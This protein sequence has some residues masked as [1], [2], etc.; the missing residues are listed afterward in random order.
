MD[1]PTQVK[2]I[3][4]TEEGAL[5]NKDNLALRQYKEQKKRINTINT[6]EDRICVLERQIEQILETGIIN[7]NS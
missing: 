3:F 2:G 6:L 1:E 5:V 4:K 7:V